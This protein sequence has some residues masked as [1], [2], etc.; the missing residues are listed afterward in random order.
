MNKAKPTQTSNTYLYIQANPS[1]NYKQ[2]KTPIYTQTHIKKKAHGLTK[3]PKPPQMNPKTRNHNFKGKEANPES[4]CLKKVDTHEKKTIQYITNKQKVI[5]TCLHCGWYGCILCLQEELLL[6]LHCLQTRVVLSCV[7]VCHCG[8]WGFALQLYSQSWTNYIFAVFSPFCL[9]FLTSFTFTPFS[10]TII[11]LWIH[12]PINHPTN[13]YLFHHYISNFNFQQ[14]Y[15]YH[16]F[17][18]H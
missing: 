7:C 8:V 5:V 2:H 10:S 6:L 11:S 9:I 18:Q 3:I 13:I 17:K 14:Q 12:L 15:Q 16:S 1:Y 4:T